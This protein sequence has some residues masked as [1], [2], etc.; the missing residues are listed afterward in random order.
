M[1]LQVCEK[2]PLLFKKKMYTT[3]F[4]MEKVKTKQ[5]G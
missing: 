1:S 5:N 4:N 3:S 2:A